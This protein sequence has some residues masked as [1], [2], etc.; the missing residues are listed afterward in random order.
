MLADL[1][2]GDQSKVDAGLESAAR[3]AM[4]PGRTRRPRGPEGAQLSPSGYLD[5]LRSRIA[6]IAGLR[7]LDDEAFRRARD[8]YRFAR[9]DYVTEQPTLA[10]DPDLGWFFE[11]ATFETEANSACNDLITTLGLQRSRASK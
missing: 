8:F 1:V 10:T 11:A 6:I 3:D 9:A 5:L 7:D 2:S 4:D